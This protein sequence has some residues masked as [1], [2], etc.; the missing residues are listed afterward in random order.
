[1]TTARILATAL[2]AGSLLLATPALAQADWGSTQVVAGRERIKVTVTGT[3]YPAGHCLIDPSFGTPDTQSIG[4]EPDGTI[5]IENLKPGTHRVSVWCPQGGVI[6]E[7]VVEVQ[8]GNPLLDLQDRA[9]AAGG[10][11]EKVS[12]PALR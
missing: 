6:G 8:P 3:E 4:M 5:V 2:A 7:S 9:Y 10:S 1:M 12:D 11:S